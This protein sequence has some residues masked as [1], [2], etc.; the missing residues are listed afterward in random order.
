MRRIFRVFMSVPGGSKWTILGGLVLATLAEGFGLA[1]L[2]PALTVLFGEGGEAPTVVHELVFGFLGAVGLPANLESLLLLV[3][4]G[5]LAKAALIALAMI[6]L[7]YAVA[8]VATDL[9]TTLLQHLLKVKWAYFT[10]EAIG[11][12]ANAMSQDATRAGRAYMLAQMFVASLLETA[13]SITLAFLVSWRL[14]VLGL[15][16]GGIILL[17]LRPF[18]RLSKKAGRGQQRSTQGF[19]TLLTDTLIGI[20]PLKAMS[21]QEHFLPLFKRETRALRRALRWETTSES[22]MSEMREPIFMAFAVVGIYLA[23]ARFTVSM[24]ELIVMAMLLYRMVGSL[25]RVQRQL[26]R[27]VT[28]E[29]SHRA[30]H[31][32]IREAASQGEEFVGTKVPTLDQACVFDRVSFAF[33]TKPVLDEVSL[34]IPANRLTVLMGPSGVG[35][36]TIADLL[37]GLFEPHAGR[38]LID[39]V[40]LPEIDLRAW[41]GM[42]GYVPQELTLFHDSVLA[43]LTLGD[44]AI[45]AEQARVALDTA[46]A[47]AFVASLPEGLLTGGRARHAAP[48]SDAA[49]DPRPVAPDRAALLI[50]D[51]VTSALDPATEARCRSRTGRCHDYRR[52]HRRAAWVDVADRVYE[53]APNNMRLAKDMGREPAPLASSG[54][55]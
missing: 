8:E 53:V 4:L 49:A 12:F 1:S 46:G 19:V 36:T 11:R 33:G 37:L 45:S 54:I 39:G 50:L 9:R 31:K 17:I 22:L 43:N 47:G 23:Q 3:L 2:L 13:M 34:T 40:P 55:C 28:L 5:V 48:G 38:I 52:D 6:R 24:S 16:V 21:R 25:G 32:M 15:A 18:V 27:A 20:K 44:P 51:E 26:Q 7:G 42:V 35:K 14:A 29:A 10:R 30:V 41:R